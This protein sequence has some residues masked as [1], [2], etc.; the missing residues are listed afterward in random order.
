MRLVAVL[1]V[2]VA[3][4]GAFFLGRMSHPTSAIAAR[5]GKVVTVAQGD[6]IRIPGVHTRCLVSEEARIPELICNHSPRGKFELALF[7]NELL[8]YRYGNPDKVAYSA[9]W[10]P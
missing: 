4:G 10:K 7:H 1:L 5:S 8:V 6:T 2:G 3:V 9:P